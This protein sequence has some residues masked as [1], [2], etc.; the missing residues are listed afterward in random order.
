MVEGIKSEGRNKRK[1]MFLVIMISY[2]WQFTIL[3]QGLL[4][5]SLF[6]D[7]FSSR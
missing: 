5:V 2:D 3:C 6:G 7:A 4:F 1:R